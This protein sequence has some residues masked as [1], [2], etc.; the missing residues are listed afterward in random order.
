MATVAPIPIGTMPHEDLN[1][2]PEP[3]I[4]LSFSTYYT[5]LK[6]K[7]SS[8]NTPWEVCIAALRLNSSVLTTQF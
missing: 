6:R 7:A 8:S 2:I 3:P 4:V 5:G 1:G